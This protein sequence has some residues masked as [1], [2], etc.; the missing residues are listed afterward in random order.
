[1]S[2]CENVLQ[3]VV[4]GSGLRGKHPPW[5]IQGMHLFLETET[6]VRMPVS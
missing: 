6:R 4:T 5:G 3:K 2:Q 1:M